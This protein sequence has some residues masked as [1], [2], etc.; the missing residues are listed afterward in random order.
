MKVIN[1]IK[2]TAKEDIPVTLLP[3]ILVITAVVGIIL[4]VRTKDSNII[5]ALATV[6][7]VMVT[8]IY[9]WHTRQLARATTNQVLNNWAPVIKIVAENANNSIKVKCKNVGIGPA[10]NM[11]CW[12]RHEE[13]PELASDANT[14]KAGAIGSGEELSY[15]WSSDLKLPSFSSGFD[16]I[17]KYNDVYKRVF[18]SRLEIVGNNDQSLQYGLENR[19]NDNVENKEKMRDTNVNKGKTITPNEIMKELKK[20]N[21]FSLVIFGASVGIAGLVLII[22]HLTTTWG[23]LEYGITLI[24][25]GII[26]VIGGYLAFKKITKGKG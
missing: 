26:V 20:S 2:E 22:E 14:R 25:Y 6:S 12:I 16:I 13:I 18:V 17:A 21:L 10:L 11:R 23:I 3:V 7:L 15:A 4:G 9:G 1:W 8:G 24:V 5:L 19:T